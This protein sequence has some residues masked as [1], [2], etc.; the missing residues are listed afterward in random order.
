VA[1]DERPLEHGWLPD[2]PVGDTVLRSFVH[3]QGEVNAAVAEAAGGRTGRT[4]DVLVSDSGTPVPYYNQ[5]VLLR[6]PDGIDDGVLDDVEAFFAGA[7]NPATLLSIW[8][9]PDLAERGW[10]L[11]GH[12]AWVVRSPGPVPEARPHAGVEVSLVTTPDELAAAERVAVE[13]YPIDEARGR[14]AGSV[15]PPGLLGSGVS[16]RLGRLDGR[17]VAVGLGHVGCGVQNLCLGATL[18]A[19]RRKGVWEALVWARVADAP[20][21]AAVAYTSDFSRPGFV[22]MGFVPVVRFTLWVRPPAS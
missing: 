12:P 15:L 10:V 1:G 6:P 11:V 14:P 16:V 18:P 8:P 19:A 21:L 7:T 4:D 9:T 22:R 20:E 3:N 5:A 17:P 13:G 2:T